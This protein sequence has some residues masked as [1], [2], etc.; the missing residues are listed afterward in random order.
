MLSTTFSRRGLLRFSPLARIG[1]VLVSLVSLL[2][3]T[4]PLYL[5]ESAFGL[6]MTQDRYWVFFLIIPLAL[7]FLGLEINR[8]KIEISALALLAVLAALAAALR[9]IGAGAVG[10]EPMWFLVILAARVFGAT[11]GFSLG[12]IA[13]AL[14][15]LL[16]GGIGPWLPFQIMAASWIG[17]LAGSLPQRVR[18]RLEIAMLMVIALVA[19]MSF[20]FLMDLQL[21]PWLLGTETA[22]SFVPGAGVE[23][24]LSRF[25]RF[26]FLTA[27]AWDIPRSI[28]TATL[29]AITGAPI[30]NALRR[31]QKKVVFLDDLSERAKAQKAL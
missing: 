25:V 8:G 4:W 28:L 20:G 6:A 22:I 5:P 18:G 14:S 3:F 19:G 2:A 26:H 27:M 9:Q 17:L 23:E 15:A 21:W 29:I 24:N 7:F 13:M 12:A 10:I 1:I 11:F 31:A 16:T 30:I